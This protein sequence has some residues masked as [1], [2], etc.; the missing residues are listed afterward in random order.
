MVC[1]RRAVSLASQVTAAV[2]ACGDPA[3]SMHDFDSRGV[4]RVYEGAV[5]D[6]GW[7]L[8]RD[9]PGCSQP[10]LGVFADGA[11]TIAGR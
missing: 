1:K 3:L 9:A 4:S 8:W 7:R 11:T 5:E 2:V 10:F 6:W